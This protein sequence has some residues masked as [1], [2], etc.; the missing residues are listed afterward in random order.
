MSFYKNDIV[1]ISGPMTGI[2]QFNRPAFFS[3]EKKILQDYKCK[4]L[5]PARITDPHVSRYHKGLKKAEL[6]REYMKHDI[7][8]IFRSTA[9]VL[10][11]GW[12]CSK[13]AVAEFSVAKS[14][15]MLVINEEDLIQP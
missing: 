11:T 14:L 12:Q 7:D 5:N 10:L 9:M 8:L 15:N 2:Y 6:Y 13:G 1:Y 3:M 4:V